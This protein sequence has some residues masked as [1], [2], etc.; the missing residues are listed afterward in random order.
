MNQKKSEKIQIWK[1]PTYRFDW[2]WCHLLD[3]SFNC[4]SCPWPR[5]VRMWTSASIT[6]EFEISE[7]EKNLL[8]VVELG[9]VKCRNTF[10]LVNRSMA[11][12]KNIFAD[13]WFSLWFDTEK[14]FETYRTF[15][16]TQWKLIEHLYYSI[17][18]SECSMSF[19][20]VLW[21]VAFCVVTFLTTKHF[22]PII[23]QKVR[24]MKRLIDQKN[25]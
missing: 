22:E 7:S 6:P 23:A 8:W 3:F 13:L 11:K 25:A 4:S 17:E 1:N 12:L 2:I 19:Y 16:R 15:Y 20:W 14:S 24:L 21:N 9:H 10:R 5:T 18:Y